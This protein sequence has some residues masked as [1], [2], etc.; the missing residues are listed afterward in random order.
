MGRKSAKMLHNKYLCTSH[1]LESGFTAD[2][3][4]HL[5]KGNEPLCS[6][7]SR[8]VI[9]ILVDNPDTFT[10]SHIIFC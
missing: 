6:V 1:F 2:E 4:I 7:A 5:N 8:C 9:L 3:R 10:H